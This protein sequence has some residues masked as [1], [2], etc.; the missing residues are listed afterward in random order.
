MAI[1]DSELRI[2]Q[3]RRVLDDSLPVEETVIVLPG[4][5]TADFGNGKIIIALTVEN[6]LFSARLTRF[7]E[8]ARRSNVTP[9]IHQDLTKGKHES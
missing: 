7:D 5:I 6:V 4:C 9:R 3:N 2:E 8:Y 1:V